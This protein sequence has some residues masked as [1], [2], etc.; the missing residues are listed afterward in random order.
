MSDGDD[1]PERCTLKG[2]ATVEGLCFGCMHAR[3]L[4]VGY[5]TISNRTWKTNYRDYVLI[6]ASGHGRAYFLSVCLCRKTSKG[7][8]KGGLATPAFQRSSPAAF[9]RLRRPGWTPDLKVPRSN[10]GGRTTF[11]GPGPLP[12]PS[13]VH[14]SLGFASAPDSRP[15]APRPGARRRPASERRR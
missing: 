11:Q 3:A 8:P 5:K 10:R 2:P 6:H 13:R 9:R 1:W 12:R 14:G 7:K 15:P 4:A